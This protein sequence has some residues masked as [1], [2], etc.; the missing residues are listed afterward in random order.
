M[1][2]DIAYTVEM[3]AGKAPPAI[4]YLPEGEHIIYPQSH[5]NGISIK[6]DSSCLPI[7]LE[8]FTNKLKEEPRPVSYY[9]HKR[10]PAANIPS[11]LDY[12]DGVGVILLIDWTIGGIKAIEGGNYSYYSPR[13]AVLNGVPIGFLEGAEI[14][15]LTNEPAF[16]T[17]DRIAASSACQ[18]NRFPKTEKKSTALETSSKETK[19]KEEP[20]MKELVM[21]GLLTQEESEKPDALEIAKAK[22]DELKKKTT[23]TSGLSESLDATKVE[24]EEVKKKVEAS[25]EAFVVASVEAGKIA[26]K[27]EEK[28][29]LWKKMYM[30][31]CV[32]ATS[33]MAQ[34]SIN[35]AFEH[36][37]ANKHAAEKTEKKGYDRLEASISAD[38]TTKKKD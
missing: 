32:L 27:D 7:L 31:D 13:V 3:N 34:I 11:G 24:L 29:A 37:I 28:K 2:D 14:G 18:I 9:D 15:S 26:P 5:P 30:S 1:P 19:P 21:L 25:A 38:I 35:P 17:I 4:V 23:E 8:A 12:I 33:T 20:K 36:V 10:G 22:L 16:T 6:V